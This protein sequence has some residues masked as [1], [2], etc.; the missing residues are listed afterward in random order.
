MHPFAH[1]SRYPVRRLLVRASRSKK[2]TA[3]LNTRGRDA[4]GQNE[5][6]PNALLSA[7]Q[8]FLFFNESDKFCMFPSPRMIYLTLMTVN[9][10][11]SNT[12]APYG[13]QEN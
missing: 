3:M 11:G 8:H 1:L 9:I 7:A 12:K 2:T 10:A 6:R 13:C 4:V 5:Q